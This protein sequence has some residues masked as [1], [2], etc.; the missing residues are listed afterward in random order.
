MKKELVGYVP[1]DSGQ[2]I[3][4]DPCYLGKWVD[5][6]FEDIRC[7]REAKTGKIF[8]YPR[9]FPAGYEQPLKGYGGKSMN[10]LLKAKK[11]K[12]IPS[13]LDDSLSYSGACR[14]TLS[15]AGAGQLRFDTGIEAAVASRTAGGDGFYPVYAYKD[16]AGAIVKLE[17][18]F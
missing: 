16:K 3:I 18:V 9:D 5:N 12:R 8:E 11:F 15:E 10:D 7:Y 2:V 14:T 13:K 1:V 17:I 4:V 6:E